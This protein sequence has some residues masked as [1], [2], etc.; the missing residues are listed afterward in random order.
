MEKL[1]IK[2]LF[3]KFSLKINNNLFTLILYYCIALVLLSLLIGQFLGDQ[4]AKSKYS[5]LENIFL[6]ITLGFLHRFI[7]VKKNIPLFQR[8]V[9]GLFIIVLSAIIYVIIFK[10][11]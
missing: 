10:I 11:I 1:N 9:I 4:F 5:I 6:G 7:L 3:L 2:D 8:I